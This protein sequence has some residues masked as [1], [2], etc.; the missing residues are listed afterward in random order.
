MNIEK[1]DNILVNMK[2][3]GQEHIAAC[4]VCESSNPKGHHLYYRQEG[5]KIL[6]NCKKSDCSYA[7]IINALGLNENPKDIGAS[8][9][10]LREHKY[11]NAEGIL[12][13]RKMFYKVGN[14]KK[15]FWERNENDKFVNGLGKI[16]IPIYNLPAVINTTSEVLYIVEGEKDV[17]TLTSLGYLSTTSPN[18]AAGLWNSDFNKYFADKNVVIIPDND[19]IGAK[20]AEKIVSALLETAKSIKVIDLVKFVPTLAIKGDISDVYN[21]LGENKTKEIIAKAIK[22]TEET[23][24]SKIPNWLKSSNGKNYIDEVIFI[25]EFKEKYN[26]VCINDTFYDFHGRMSDGQIKSHIQSLIANHFD[27]SLANKE[28]SIYNALKNSCY[29]VS[30]EPAIN[31]I[32]CLNTT[33]MVAKFEELKTQPLQ[34][35]LNRLNVNYNPE[36]P[37]PVVFKKYL[38]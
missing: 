3:R 33:I 22:E 18:G 25:Q 36:A 15:F 21:L 5:N 9:S 23:K 31:Q 37:D 24:S 35:A 11:L 27:K 13:A 32:N 8:R 30:P 6:F 38:R 4:P 10:L 19:A 26:L 20:Y 2:I 7:E 28:K 1:L 29:A 34:V 14:T 12:I 17:D 16:E